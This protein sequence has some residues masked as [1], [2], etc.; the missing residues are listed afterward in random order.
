[1]W[2]KT[3]TSGGYGTGVGRWTSSSTTGIF[4]LRPASADYGNR[5]IFIT[6]DDSG[7]GKFVDSGVK[8]NDGVWHHLAGLGWITIR[9]FVMVLVKKEGSYGHTVNTNTSTGLREIW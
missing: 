9:L 4:D 8:V 5:F 7:T 1:M 6:R 3:T 2:V